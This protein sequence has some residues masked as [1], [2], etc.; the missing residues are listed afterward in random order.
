M[1]QPLFHKIEKSK[2]KIVLAIAFLFWCAKIQVEKRVEVRKMASKHSMDLTKGSVLKKLVIF[3]I[4]IVLSNILQQLYHAADVIVVGNFATDSRTALAAVGSTG[5]VTTLILNLFLGL[6]VGANVVCANL[7][8]ERRRDSL[9]CAMHSCIVFSLICGIAVS[10]MG[11]LLSEKILVLMGSPDGVR[12][13]ATKYM[14]IIFL[15]QPANLM[16]NFGSGILRAYGDT[17]RPLY[18]LSAAGMINVILNVILVMLSPDNAAS[19]VAIATIVS[20]YVSAGIVLR[21][22]FHPGGDQHLSVSEMKI[23][24]EEFLNIVKVGI[25]CGLNSI[26]FNITN[27]II[28]VALNILG[29]VALAANSAACNIDGIPFQIL[30]GVTAACVSFAG[31]NYGAKKLDRIDKLLSRSI[32][33]TLGILSVMAALIFSFSDFFMGLFANGDLEVIAMGGVRLKIMSLGYMIYAVSEMAVGCLRGMGKTML[34]MVL[35]I[36]AI[37]ITRTLWILLLFPRFETLAFLL[38]SYPVSWILSATAQLICY[39]VCRKKEGEKLLLEQSSD[40]A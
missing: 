35:N 32:L 6:A 21:I 38:Y 27:V 20:W 10:V 12:E 31:Q 30:A 9:R 16:F 25:P 34:P 26:L 7:Y 5:S 40:P 8:G 23:H 19:C 4:P 28:T 24:R 33:V 37:C 15:G 3:A 18:I 11:F 39:F 17:K 2:K 1:V 36:S 13:Q 22:L 29:P 14:Q